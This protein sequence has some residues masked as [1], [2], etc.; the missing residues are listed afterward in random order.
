[1]MAPEENHEKQ[2]SQ[3]SGR[4]EVQETTHHIC[5]QKIAVWHLKKAHHSTTQHSTAQH[6]PTQHSTAQ[7]S[8]TQHSTAQHS[9]AQHNTTQHSTAQHS[10]ALHCTAL[11]CTAKLIRYIHTL[12][13][14]EF[15]FQDR[16]K[17]TVTYTIS[18]NNNLFRHLSLVATHKDL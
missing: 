2:F 14:R 7:H 1:M 12:Y 4:K 6:S 9:T 5:G 10:T 3:K 13:A 16:L 8:T 15:T 18:I 11:H 17:L